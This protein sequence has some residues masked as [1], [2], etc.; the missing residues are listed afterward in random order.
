MSKKTDGNN[1]KYEGFDENMFPEIEEKVNVAA[2]RPFTK[3]RAAEM[4]LCI[5]AIVLGLLYLYTD[6]VSL[7]VLL[8]AFTVGMAVIT[9]LRVFDAKKSGLK[10]W[11]AYISAVFSGL[12]TLLVGGVTV[13]YFRDT[14]DT[15]LVSAMIS[16]VVNRL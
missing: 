12:L 3:Y 13:V 8:P 15:G 6:Y 11:V 5:L 9:V 2:V 1:K 7:G 4:V 16:S 14:A 10:G